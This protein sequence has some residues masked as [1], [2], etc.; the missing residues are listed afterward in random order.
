MGEFK[1]VWEGKSEYTKSL[2]FTA[3]VLLTLQGVGGRCSAETA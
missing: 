2:D 1:L 3:L